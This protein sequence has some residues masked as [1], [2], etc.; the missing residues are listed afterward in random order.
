MARGQ[1]FYEQPHLM[2]H[3][4]M[5]WRQQVR[6]EGGGLMKR[7]VVCVCVWGGGQG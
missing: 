4:Q 3:W 1:G 2:V 7:W 5:L 6:E